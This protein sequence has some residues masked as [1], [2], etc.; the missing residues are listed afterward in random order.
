MKKNFIL[1]SVLLAMCGLTAFAQVPTVAV[2]AFDIQAG[3][4]IT[5]EEAGIVYELFIAELVSTR[6]VNVVDRVN[7]D[8]ILAEMRFQASDWSNPEKTT[9][10]GRVLNAEIIVWGRF[11]K[12]GNHIYWAVTML[13]LKTAAIYAARNTRL[14][15]IGEVWNVLPNFCKDLVQ[16][17]TT[18]PPDA[19]GIPTIAVATFDVQG[20]ITTTDAEVVTELFINSLANQNTVRVVDR[21]NFDKIIGE[22]HF[23]STDWSNSEKTVALGRVLNA[24]IVVRGQ[25]MQMGGNIFWT[26]TILDVNTAQ[27]LSSSRLQ[28]NSIDEVWPFRNNRGENVNN[29]SNFTQQIISQLPPPNYFVGRWEF[30]FDSWERSHTGGTG[31]YPRT[32]RN[33]PSSPAI[34]RL[35]IKANG[36]IIVERFDT[37][38]VTSNREGNYFFDNVRYTTTYGNLNR[39][40]RGTGTYG[41]ITKSSNNIFYI[42][43]SLRLSGLDSGI[44]TS[45]TTRAYIYTDYPNGLSQLS[46]TPESLILL[47]SGK[48]ANRVARFYTDTTGKASFTRLPTTIP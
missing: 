47:D 26:A 37:I 34:I 13:D 33:R 1:I 27:I 9:S 46:L 29:L 18:P 25:L 15:N 10:L 40:G 6:A 19:P 3:S 32:V 48:E 8:R 39:N 38:T 4:G 21:V 23:Q 30:S 7:L 12:M 24:G 20:G 2:A 17:L 44:P 16:R 22:M 45:Q 14:G 41:A 31:G 43:I 11:M 28:L 36:T 35:D 42:T 5:Q